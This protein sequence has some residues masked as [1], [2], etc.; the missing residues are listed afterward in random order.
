MS[1]RKRNNPLQNMS[2]GNYVLMFHSKGASYS[3]VGGDCEFFKT[4]EDAL[5]FVEKHGK[6]SERWFILKVDDMVDVTKTLIPVFI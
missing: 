1:D 6:L 3:M 2:K 4:R 5:A